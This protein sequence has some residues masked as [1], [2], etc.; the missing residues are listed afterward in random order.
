MNAEQRRAEVE[1]EERR[2]KGDRSRPTG[3]C[4]ERD[5]HPR[6]ARA[7][8]AVDNHRT[9]PE[10]LAET[11]GAQRGD[12]ASEPR[13]DERRA[14]H[15]RR[16]LQ[17]TR[18]KQDQHRCLHVMQQLPDRDRPRE[19]TQHAVMPD[20]LQSFADLA[21]HIAVR[22]RRRDRDVPYPAQQQCR[23][24]ERQ[25][26]D[27][28]RERRREHLDQPA[29]EPWT[30]ELRR[31]L[32]EHDA[33]VRLDQLVTTDH[34]RHQHLCRRTADRVAGADRESRDIE[35]RHRQPVSEGRKRN[36]QQRQAA[37]D[38]RRNDDP[39][40]RSTIDPHAGEKPQQSERQHLERDQHA[41]LPRA[42]VQQQRRR[43]RQCEIGDLGAERRDRCRRP[44]PP[45]VL[46]PED[47]GIGKPVAPPCFESSFHLDLVM[48]A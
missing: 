18:R 35:H 38:L 10:A 16:H 43:Q 27:H 9:D 22:M 37:S 44:Q 47:A 5:H 20:E 36:D 42:C 11:L 29:G 14:D 2:A 3:R 15:P 46:L 33:R 32:A 8:E 1:H 21:P 13:D 41:H 12:E 45:E 31:V 34:L 25:R 4:D 24:E 17:L 39:E 30:G 7:D 19:R 40:L 23:A 28:D 26:V 48:L 6:R